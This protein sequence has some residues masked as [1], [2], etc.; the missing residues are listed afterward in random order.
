MRIYK[1]GDDVVAKL[2]KTKEEGMIEEEILKDISDKIWRGY[3]DDFRHPFV[4]EK[5]LPEYWMSVWGLNKELTEVRIF[6]EKT[7]WEG[8]ADRIMDS[9]REWFSIGRAYGGIVHKV[10]LP[11]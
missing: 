7:H 6:E 1:S 5:N 4:V 2:Y 3:V 10:Y 9:Q 11:E 8:D